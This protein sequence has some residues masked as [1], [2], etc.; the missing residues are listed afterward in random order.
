M[1]LCCATKPCPLRDLR[2][3]ECCCWRW[4]LSG[5]WCRVVCKI[6]IVVDFVEELP[7]CIFWLSAVQRRTAY[8]MKME[9]VIP[10]PWN[11][12]NDSI[13]PSKLR[14]TRNTIVLHSVSDNS[15]GG[16]DIK[17]FRENGNSV[18]L[19]F[20]FFFLNAKNLLCFFFLFVN[21]FLNLLIRCE[22]R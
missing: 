2:L 16:W 12:Y 4:G 17:T 19:Y 21:S 1:T 10:P 9:S 6:R 18:Y 15:P 13:C 8:T 11:V 14:C 20:F 3:S 22:D 7:A 5:T